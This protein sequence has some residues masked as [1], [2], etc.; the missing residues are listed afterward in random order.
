MRILFEEL[1]SQ[2]VKVL[3][4]DIVDIC[5]LYSICSCVVICIKLV[6]WELEM[7]FNYYNKN[8]SKNTA[9][10]LFYSS[11]V[12]SGSFED[13]REYIK[14]TKVDSRVYKRKCV[15]WLNFSEIRWQRKEQVVMERRHYV[16]TTLEFTGKFKGPRICNIVRAWHNK[17]RFRKRMRLTPNGIIPKGL[18]RS[19]WLFWS[20]WD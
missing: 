18:F 13:Q 12:E 14:Y 17:L 11:F 10:L 3:M 20:E 16:S 9:M 5:S 8:S 15:K 1:G 2:P 19:E 7:V 4:K 6:L